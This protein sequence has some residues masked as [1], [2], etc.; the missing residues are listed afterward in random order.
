M[1]LTLSNITEICGKNI[2]KGKRK[3]GCQG[4]KSTVGL[5]KPKVT[6]NCAGSTSL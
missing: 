2:L 1:F 4:R 5:K 6:W 3:S